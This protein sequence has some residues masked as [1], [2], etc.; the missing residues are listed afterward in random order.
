MSGPP[1][2]LEA[3]NQIGDMYLALKGKGLDK[4]E[5]LRL[6]EITLGAIVPTAM[7]ERSLSALRRVAGAP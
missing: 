7:R 6:V 5:A 2:F 4:D 3:V 1:D